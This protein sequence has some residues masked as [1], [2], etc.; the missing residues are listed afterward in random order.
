MAVLIAGAAY[1]VYYY[2]HRFVRSDRDLVALLPHTDTT[3]FYANIAALRNG[4]YLKALGVSE[5]SQEAEYR[6]FLK[7]TEF[8]YE[9]DLESLAGASDGNQLFFVVKG[10]FQWPSLRRYATD[11]GGRCDGAICSAPASTPGKWASFLEIQPDVLALA[12]SGDRSA[13]LALS[14][15]RDIAPKTLPQWPVWVNVSHSVLRDP[16]KLPLALRIFAITLQ[17][18]ESVQL[19]LA[20]DTSGAAVFD[21]RLDAVCANKPSAEAMRNQMEIQTKMLKLELAR[22]NHQPDPRDISGLMLE[23]S[24]QMVDRSIIGLWPVHRELLD[25]LMGG[26]Q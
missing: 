1:G 17:S 5:R 7:Q 10:R 15:R 22:E 2:R 4:G 19:S 14:P 24:F 26:Q 13:V 6:E 12:V 16:L 9:R 21:I 18:A 25:T 3:I 8:D 20:P 23:G 11:H